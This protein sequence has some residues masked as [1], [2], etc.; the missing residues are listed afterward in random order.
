MVQAPGWLVFI[1]DVWSL[2]ADLFDYLDLK[3]DFTQN[4]SFSQS[5][6]L[7]FGQNVNYYWM[8]HFSKQ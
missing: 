5:I 6:K 3:Q 7:V 1:N 2:A 4:Q 8:H